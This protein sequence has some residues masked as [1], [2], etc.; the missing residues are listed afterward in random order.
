MPSKKD[1]HAQALAALKNQTTP[2]ANSTNTPLSNSYQ[3]TKTKTT[4]TT[5]LKNDSVISLDHLSLIRELLAK[6]LSIGSAVNDTYSN[7]TKIG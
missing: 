7:S 4:T 1:K 3:I 5:N 2:L 6:H